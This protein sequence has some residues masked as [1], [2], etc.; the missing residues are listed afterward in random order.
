MR[1]FYTDGQIIKT[2][3]AAADHGITAVWT[4]CYDRWIKLWSEY[5]QQGGKMKFWIAQPHVDPDKMKDDITLA[6]KNGAKAICIQGIRV[7]EQ[8]NAG[9]FDVV[10]DWLE[11]I[12]SY[13][14]PAGMAT[15]GAKTHLVAEDKGLPTDFY[16]Q[17]L[18]RPDTYVREGLE[19]S[20][21]TIEKL[22][23]PVVAYKA[24]GAGRIMP[25]ETLPYI[26]KRLKPKDGVCI[27][28]YPKTRDELAENASLIQRLSDR[29]R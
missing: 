5:Q 15:H 19:E 11:H 21:A 23:K 18:Y 28:V 8:M 7:D 13:G 24:L 29:E 12:K 16:H 14:L 26:F 6:A 27:G 17:T 25:S 4:P 2:L 3:D 22:H 9:K 10:R 1:D 20:L